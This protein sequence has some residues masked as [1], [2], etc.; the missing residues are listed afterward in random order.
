MRRPLSWHYAPGLFWFRVFGKGL[1]I[2]DTSRHR[3]LFS[4][5]EGHRAM[6][7]IRKLK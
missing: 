2:R 6:W 4:E 5:R 7:T 3:L 1:H